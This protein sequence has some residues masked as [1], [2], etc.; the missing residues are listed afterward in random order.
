MPPVHVSFLTKVRLCFPLFQVFYS[1]TYRCGRHPNLPGVDINQWLESF[2][3]C[4]SS[5]T[6]EK[7]IPFSVYPD[8]FIE[9][10]LTRFSFLK[11]VLNFLQGKKNSTES[12]PTSNVLSLMVVLT[13][14][15]VQST[16][17]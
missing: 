16:C 9:R 4:L 11:A 8:S 5:A 7:G 6:Q 17:F 14:Y 10:T 3:G 15:F 12:K 1:R 2:L 13:S